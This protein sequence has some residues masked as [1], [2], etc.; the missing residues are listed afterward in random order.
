[1]RNNQRRSGA[2]AQSPAPVSTPVEMAYAIPTEFVELPSRGIFYPDD[3]PLYGQET[4]EIKY[5]T[6]KE[7]DILASTALLSKGLT[8]DRL[9]SSIILLDIDPSTLLIGDR[10]AIMIAARIS[11]Y[12][13]AYNAQVKCQQCYVKDPYVFSLEKTNLTEN[14]FDQDFLQE[15]SA[16]FNQETKTFDVVL[17][18]SKASVG[19]RLFNGADEKTID[20]DI[21]E[22][23]AVTSVLSKFVVSVDGKTDPQIIDSFISNMLAADSRYI[24]NLYPKLAPNIDLKQQFVCG[25]CAHKEEM[26][27]PLSAEF[28]WTR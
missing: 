1:M 21:G 10:N 27:V 5:M 19:V 16:T 17:P 2:R 22:E 13:S 25:N 8:I 7:E 12:G 6:A 9:L 24:R 14:C 4:I 20:D 28:F 11:A 3:H 26:E 15:N 23:T 18:K